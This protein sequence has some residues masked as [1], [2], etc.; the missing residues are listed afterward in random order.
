MDKEYNHKFI[1]DNKIEYELGMGTGAILNDVLYVK[2]H[3]CYEL[4]E[5]SPLNFYRDKNGRIKRLCKVCTELR[6]YL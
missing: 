3:G 1:T 5:A 6:Y 4:L 2:C